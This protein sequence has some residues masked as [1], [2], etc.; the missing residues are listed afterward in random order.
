MP[1]IMLFRE[2]HIGSGSQL[3]VT[4]KPDEKNSASQGFAIHNAFQTRLPKPLRYSAKTTEY[5]DYLNANK[6]ND[7]RKIKDEVYEAMM[8]TYA[9]MR[10]RMST[11]LIDTM[12]GKETSQYRINADDRFDDLRRKQDG[13]GSHSEDKMAGQLQAIAQ[14]VYS[15]TTK[16]AETP[17]DAKGANDMV[18]QFFGWYWKPNAKEGIGL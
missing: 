1:A 3:H 11:G 5:N 16:S 10:T 13:S 7:H 9:A 8:G 18:M 4:P 15:E 17:T 2:S 6:T 12:P 14:D